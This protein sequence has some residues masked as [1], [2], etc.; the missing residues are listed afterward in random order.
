MQRFAPETLTISGDMWLEYVRHKT[1]DRPIVFIHGYGDSWYSFAG[2]LAALPAGYDAVAPSLRGHGGAAKPTGAYRIED[3][4]NDVLA[5]V[6]TLGLGPAIFV[7]HSMGSFIAQEIGLRAPARVSH[8]VL[9]ASA[10]TADSKGLRDLLDATLQLRDPVPV[11]FVRDFQTG[12]CV[13]PLGGGMDLERIVEESRKLPA[14]VWQEALRGLISY[15][16]AASEY[17]ALR[18]INRPTLIL[19]GRSDEIFDAEQQSL[20]RWHIPASKLIV[21]ERSGHALNWEFPRETMEQVAG[22]VS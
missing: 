6:E 15:R 12:T 18:R 16:P 14:H 1:G 7:G 22:F 5:L 20:L 2:M 3:L 4:A 11:S 8:L 21:N 9:I 19:W 10:A 13:N 17:P